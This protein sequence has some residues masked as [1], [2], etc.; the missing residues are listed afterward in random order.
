VSAL[1]L[2]YGLMSLGSLPLR[3]T[4]L[5]TCPQAPRACPPGFEPPMTSGENL[6]VEAGITLGVIALLAVV[7]AME[8]R[9]QPRL[10]LFG[11]GPSAQ[12]PRP[13]APAPPPEMK[14]SAIVKKPASS[15]MPKMGSEDHPA[16]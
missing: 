3:L 16:D 13:E 14:A 10:R 9:Y 8:L 12:G 1:A 2:T 5:G 6:A 15:T 11:R 4:V 7:T